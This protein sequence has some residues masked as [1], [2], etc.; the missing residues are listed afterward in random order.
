[1]Q[2]Q[3]TAEQ[4]SDSEVEANN[5]EDDDENLSSVLMQRKVE[6]KELRMGKSKRKQERG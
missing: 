2:H 3:A 6:H 5:S 1:M 4:V